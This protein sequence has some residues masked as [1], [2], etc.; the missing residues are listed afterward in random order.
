V[1][2]KMKFL[3]YSTLLFSFIYFLFYFPFIFSF[4]FLFF[5]LSYPIPNHVFPTQKLTSSPP[6][7]VASYLPQR[8]HPRATALHR[9]TVELSRPCLVVLLPEC[10]RTM[11]LFLALLLRT[12]SISPPPSFAPT[13]QGAARSSAPSL[14][15]G[16]REAT[17]RA[18]TAAVQGG[19]GRRRPDL[20]GDG[21]EEE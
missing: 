12:S 3:Y 11:R 8:R 16:S 13:S 2:K 1:D 4:S 14:A 20:D 6:P 17:R 10:R 19:Q 21:K 5:S 7:P 18:S 15:A 9:A